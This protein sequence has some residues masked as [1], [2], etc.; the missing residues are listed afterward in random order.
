MSII[1]KYGSSSETLDILNK[2]FFG[3]LLSKSKYTYSTG[4]L[5]ELPELCPMLLSKIRNFIGKDESIELDPGQTHTITVKFEPS[6]FGQKQGA[7][8]FDH[9]GISP[10]S[11]YFVSLYGNAT[12]PDVVLIPEVTAYSMGDGRVNKVKRKGF[13]IRNDGNV[14]LTVSAIS[15][16]NTTDFKLVNATGSKN[17]T[18]GNMDYF[19]LPISIS[20]YFLRFKCLCWEC[21]FQIIKDVT[22]LSHGF[23]PF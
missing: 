9:D 12:G 14:T 15:I 18:S 6:H 21:D 3:S 5:G 17:I 19:Y 22:S 16:T 20:D 10:A 7:I 8:R 23:L 13:Y 4:Q 1:S 11:P 2:K